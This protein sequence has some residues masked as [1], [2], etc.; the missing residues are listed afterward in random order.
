MGS[1]DGNKRVISST[2]IV[3]VYS[4]VAD[5]LKWIAAGIAARLCRG[6]MSRKKIPFYILTA[7]TCFSLI[8]FLQISHNTSIVNFFRIYISPEYH[9]TKTFQRR[10][11]IDYDYLP[12]HCQ[13][14]AKQFD[15]CQA[16]HRMRQQQQR[17]MYSFGKR[18]RSYK[19]ITPIIVFACHRKWCHSYFGHCEP[20]A[21]I[22]DRYRFLLSQIDTVFSASLKEMYGGANHPVVK[23]KTFTDDFTC[24][25]NVQIDAP[26]NGL[27]QIESSL[28]VDPG[29][30]FS[31]LFHYRSY[32]VSKRELL[33]FKDILLQQSQHIQ[34]HLYYYSHFTPSQY[35]ATNDYNA[36]LFHIIYKPD[37]QLRRDIDYHRNNILHSRLPM[38]ITDELE[39]KVYTTIGILYHT[40]DSIDSSTQSS[41]DLISGWDKMY[42][43]SLTLMKKLLFRQD[44]YE[45]VRFF[46]ATDSPIVTDHV[47]QHYAYDTKGTNSSLSFALPFVPVYV[48]DLETDSHLRGS[49]D[50]RSSLLELYLLSGCDA[51]AVNSL[52]A[53]A[54]DGTDSQINRF[55]TLAKKIGFLSN[56]NFCKCTSR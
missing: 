44:D 29:G 30:W 51:I 38:P 31:E 28:Y 40:G 13:P 55:A 50:D 36:C 23:M 15:A 49:S 22:G 2:S 8:F 11:S 48:V 46:L 37:D 27:Q 1:D 12:V 35:D 19:F 42:E 7:I 6:N 21:G 26:T 47:R 9:L 52:T 17:N 5:A 4:S 16:R 41:D 18:V 25:G 45:N 39:Q 43:C 53:S 10:T 33:P 20:C 24:Y 14:I 34:R 54:N 3:V 56:T 32:S